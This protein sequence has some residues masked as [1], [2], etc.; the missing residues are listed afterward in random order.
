M[1][2][3]KIKYIKVSKNN[4][5]TAII[6]QNKIF[7]SEDGSLNLKLAVDKKL[8]KKVFGDVKKYRETSD[9]WLCQVNNNFIGITGIY[10]YFEY[11]HDAWLGWFG[12][13]P[14]FRKKGYGEKILL[15]TMSESKK[16]GFIDFRLYTD[17]DDNDKA[18]NL[19][20]KIGMLEEFYI[21]EDMS[22]EKIVIFSKNLNK[23][24]TQKLGKKNLFLKKQEEIQQ[25][26]KSN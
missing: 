14:E 3:I 25:I 4:L 1:K 6:I 9:Y 21:T 2:E 19:Y 15:W 18:V 26:S 16:R 12:I 5:N 24:K 17:L 22:P 7:P 10:S 11:P 23:D 13:L 20:R 8:I